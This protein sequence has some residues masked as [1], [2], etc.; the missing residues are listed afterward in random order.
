[1]TTTTIRRIVGQLLLP[2]TVLAAA[3]FAAGVISGW[4]EYLDRSPARE[5][6]VPG[7]SAWW[8][9]LAVAAGACAV[10]GYAR[11]RHQ[12]RF[13][14]GSGRL[15]LL[16]P[17]GKPAARRSA[18]TVL[19]ALRGPSGFGRALLALLPAGLLC[20]CFWRAGLQVTAGLDPNATVNAWGGPSYPG[21]MACHYLDCCVLIAATAWLLDR[22][23]LPAE[24]LPELGDDLR[25]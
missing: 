19:A 22:I 2:L 23:L 3:L 25:G 8:P 18:R 14:R 1:M 20:Y 7:S 6:Y 11:W 17:L 10:F 24:V 16:A 9:Q 15:W 5:K 4:L 21:A 12:R 13:G